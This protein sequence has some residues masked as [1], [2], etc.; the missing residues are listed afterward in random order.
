MKSS[1]VTTAFL[2]V[3]LIAGCS[4]TPAAGPA[5]PQGPAGQEIGIGI[6]IG[7][8]L[9]PSHVRLDN[10]CNRIMGERTASEINDLTR[11]SE[12]VI[13]CFGGFFGALLEDPVAGVLQDDGGHICSD[14]LG[15]LS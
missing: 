7:S 12:K 6:E 8:R 14:E 10:T 3:I 15:L 5:G 4:A 9:R 1:L 2:L 13:Q 11:K